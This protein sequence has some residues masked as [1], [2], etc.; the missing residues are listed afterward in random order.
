MQYVVY[1][2]TLFFFDKNSH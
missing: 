2:F 1:T